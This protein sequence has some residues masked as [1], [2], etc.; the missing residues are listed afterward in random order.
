MDIT[1]VFAKQEWFER[2]Q[3]GS[4]TGSEEALAE[5]TNSFVGFNAD[6]GPV[7]ISFYDRGFEARN[8]HGLG[9][10]GLGAYQSV[11]RMHY[12]ADFA[13]YAESFPQSN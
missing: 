8:L 7:E 6:K 12:D 13:V 3:D 10:C 2:A 4:Q 1:R 11:Y 9:Y 5:A